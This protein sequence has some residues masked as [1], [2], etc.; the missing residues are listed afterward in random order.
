MSKGSANDSLDYCKRV[1]S[2]AHEFG[3]EIRRRRD[4]RR[5]S[6]ASGEAVSRLT[7]VATL[8]L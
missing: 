2:C 7:H 4:R 1:G 8:H 6:D 5:R 3:R